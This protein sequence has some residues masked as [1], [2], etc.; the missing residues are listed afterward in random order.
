VPPRT[1][2]P[3]SGDVATLVAFID[4]L[5]SQ[6][7]Q[8]ATNQEKAANFVKIQ[9]AR[10]DAVK[11]VLALNPDVATRKSVVGAGLEILNIFAQARV[12]GAMA[13]RLAFAKLL[14]ND[15]EPDIARVG[16]YMIFEAN[17]AQILSEPLSDGKEIVTQVKELLD[18]E[19]GDLTPD[20]LNLAVNAAN[21]LREQGIKEDSATILELLAT[22]VKDHPKYGELEP[23]LREQAQLARADLTGTLL[24]DV[25]TG[26]PEAETKLLAAVKQL[27]DTAEP[28]AAV[29]SE[30]HQVA[31]RLEI[32]DRTQAALQCLDMIQ[33]KFKDVSDEKLAEGITQAVRNARTRLA[34][35]GQ[36]FMV[37][38]L[39]LDGKPFDWSAYQGKVVLVD[40]WAT[41]CEPCIAELPSIR[42]NYELFHDAGFEVVG[43]SLDTKLDDLKDFMSVQEL[44]WT[45][46]DQPGGPRW[47]GRRTLDA[48]VPGKERRRWAAVPAAGG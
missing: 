48:G 36:P 47:Q 9:V 31:R 28:S 27:L 8:G 18:A 10:L 30:V 38:G 12:P 14:V 2:A 32:A 6:D 45:G 24:V 40:F 33:A 34:L 25:F 29:F 19:K 11:K 17:L 35:V 3:P 23:R 42:K 43:V 13:Q 37:E 41:W 20:A 16:R 39:T 44:P 22:T 4:Q 7:P 26:E 5:A 21:S 15:K 46:G 1:S